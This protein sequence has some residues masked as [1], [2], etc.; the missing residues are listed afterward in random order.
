MSQYRITSRYAKALIDLGVEKDSLEEMHTDV[1]LIVDAFD[2][3]RELAVLCKNPILLPQK[4]LA[5]L[6]SLLKDKV[7]AI[8]FKF[9]EVIVRKNRSH[10]IPE[11]M[12]MF[13]VKYK[14]YRQISDAILYTAS[15][16]REETKSAVVDILTKATGEKIELST[17]VDEEMIG[18]FMIKYKDRLLDASVASKLNNLRKELLD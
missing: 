8:T 9:I 3:S 6:S 14:S 17:V 10:L 4:K 1:K 2:E 7:N 5:I 12:D 18:G 11:V 15:E 13:L 16:A